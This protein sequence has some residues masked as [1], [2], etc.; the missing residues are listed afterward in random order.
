MEFF[1]MVK[2]VFGSFILAILFSISLLYMQVF[3]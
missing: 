3:A 1:F 2:E